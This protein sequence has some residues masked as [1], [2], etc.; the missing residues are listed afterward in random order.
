MEDLQQAAA[1][2]RAVGDQQSYQQT[3]YFIQQ[4]QQGT[5]MSTRP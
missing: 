5:A 1:L 2:F 4:V 3:L